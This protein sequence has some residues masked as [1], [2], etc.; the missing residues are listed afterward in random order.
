MNRKEAYREL[1][2]AVREADRNP[3][4]GIPY[5]IRVKDLLREFPDLE[6]RREKAL[7]GA[8]GRMAGESYKKPVEDYRLRF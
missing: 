8:E 2:M 6:S 5:L 1:R 4:T 3:H 7:E